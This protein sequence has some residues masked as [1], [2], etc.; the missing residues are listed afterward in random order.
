[1]NSMV[2]IQTDLARRKGR[3]IFTFLS[4]VVA[5]ALFGVLAAVRSGMLGQLSIASAERLDTANKI[6][7]FGFQPLSHYDKIVQVPGVTAVTYIMGI[8]GHY[9]E[10]NNVVPMTFWSPTAFQVFSEAKVPAVELRAWADDPQGVIAGPALVQRMGWK[11]GET[12]PIQSKIPQKNGATTWYFHLDGIYH[13]DLPQ[14]Y[15]GLFFGHYQYFNEGVA[16][17]AL[18]NVVIH[19]DERIDDPRNA[20]RIS[21]AIDALFANSSPQTLTQPE[22]QES[23][24][25]VRQFGN[26]TAMVTYVGIAVFFS[27]L[28]IVGN[29][30]AQTVRERTAE[31]AMFRA[32][33]FGPG[34][35]NR[36][37]LGEA[38]LLMVSGAV[39]GV[40]LGWLVTGLI[41]PRVGNLLPTFGM[42][43]SAAVAGTMLSV[44]FAVLVSLVPMQRITGLRVAEAL[45]KA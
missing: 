17:P 2:L 19:F 37:L 16:V 23:I 10:P 11:V 27:L 1:M 45:R 40:A 33:G 24:S 20:E 3:T 41:Y 13:A 28:L 44:V 18:Q 9:R 34:R 8:P 22:I 35:I 5:F 15:Q 7:I 38:L 25:Q 32:L 14:A 43:W 30:L 42:T 31:F 36:I 12:L 39:A 21:A 4:I 26:I 6:N 29:S